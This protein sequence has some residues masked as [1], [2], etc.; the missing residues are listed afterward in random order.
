MTAAMATMNGGVMPMDHGTIDFNTLNGTND[1]QSQSSLKGADW[2]KFFGGGQKK[3]TRGPSL[4]DLSLY[5]H[6]NI[7]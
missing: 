6:T 5:W 3:V 7:I 2:F 4:V 1:R